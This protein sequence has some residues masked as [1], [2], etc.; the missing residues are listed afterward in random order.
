MARFFLDN[1]FPLGTG[2]ELQRMGHDI[3]S[4]RSTNREHCHD[5]DQ[6]LYAAA[7]N[8]ILVT[9]NRRDFVLL[10]DAW[11]R[12]SRAWDI[13]EQHAGV[14]VLRQGNTYRQYAKHIAEYVDQLE[15]VANVLHLQES[16]GQWVAFAHPA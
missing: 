9:H 11:R 5:E 8:R 6:L 10:H 4:A 13:S 12:W 2:I 7:E 16:D 15:Q 14:L 3:S 1:D